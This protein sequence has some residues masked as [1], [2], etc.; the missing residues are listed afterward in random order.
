MMYAITPVL[1]NVKTLEIVAEHY[2]RMHGDPVAVPRLY[3]REFRKQL[4]GQKQ[5][6]S[7]V[8]TT[9]SSRTPSVLYIS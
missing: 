3:L 4:G 1:I 5:R 8:A 6:I 7:L 9:G 2:V